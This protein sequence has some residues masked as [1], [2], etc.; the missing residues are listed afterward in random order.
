MAKNDNNAVTKK[1]LVEVLGTFTETVLL[2]AVD[3]MLDS[4]FGEYTRVVDNKFAKHTHE[5]KDY[6]DSKLSAQKGDIIEYIKGGHTKEMKGYIDGKLDDQ[7]VYIDGKFSN[8]K[9]D[10]IAYIKGDRERDNQWK[11]KII[12]ILKRNKLAKPTE[13][14]LLANFVR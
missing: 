8:Q 9:D 4:R 2:P 7:K 5:M 11:L 3:N 12:D 14:E 6:I 10:I 1:E 13:L